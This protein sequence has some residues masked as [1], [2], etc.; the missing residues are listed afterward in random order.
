MQAIIELASSGETETIARFDGYT[1][2]LEIQLM[3]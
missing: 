2:P 3:K 1:S